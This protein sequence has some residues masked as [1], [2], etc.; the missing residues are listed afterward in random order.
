MLAAPWKVLLR[1]AV[2]RASHSRVASISHG[3]LHLAASVV[4]PA[5]RAERHAAVSMRRLAYDPLGFPFA[6]R[7]WR[8][9]SGHVD[10]A[11]LPAGVNSGAEHLLPHTVLG[12]SV[13]LRAPSGSSK[14]VLYISFECNLEALRQTGELPA[15]SRQYHICCATSWSPIEFGVLARAA[16]VSSAPLLVGISNRA[17]LAALSAAGSALSPSDILASDWVDVT[18][19]RPREAGDRDIDIIMI[20]HFAAWKRHWI[21][22]EALR[23]LPPDLRVVIVGRDWD[24][25]TAS[26]VLA[27]ARA[28]GVRQQVTVFS[29]LAST[30]VR[31][32]LC[33]SRL[34]TIVSLREGSCVAVAEALAADCPVVMLEE[35]AIGSAAFI[36][37]QTG[38]RASRAGYAPAL[39]DVLRAPHRFTARQ[40]YASHSGALNASCRLQDQVWELDA[41]LGD[42]SRRPLWPLRWNYVPEVMVAP[43]DESL[44]VARTRLLLAHGVALQDFEPPT[45]PIQSMTLHADRPG[46]QL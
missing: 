40:W 39:A 29:D 13:I 18:Q 30:N 1:D 2:A 21:L 46:T 7:A 16:R 19:Y 4:A 20:G 38:V 9:V 43:D 3:A 12:T 5:A 24:G 22:F 11:P 45:H 32:L 42:A 15:I 36:H 8:R 23:K 31:A 17:D 41:R 28:F 6:R 34:K 10:A 26:S 44:Q 25:R 14:G 27:D 37:D 35:S 33:R